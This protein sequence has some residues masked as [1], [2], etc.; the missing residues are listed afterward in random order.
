MGVN[1]PFIT[2]LGPS[3]LL[4]VRLQD[5]VNLGDSGLGLGRGALLTQLV[6]S[7]HAVGDH[8][9]AATFQVDLALIGIAFVEHI[10]N[11]AVIEFVL[12]LRQPFA[13]AV[14]DADHGQQHGIGD[15]GRELFPHAEFGLQFLG[16]CCTCRRIVRQ[17]V[18]PAFN[19]KLLQGFGEVADWRICQSQAIDVGLTQTTRSAGKQQAITAFDPGWSC[20]R[21]TRK[22]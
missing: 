5:A 21:Q 16:C 1:N 22:Q 7:M 6:A 18:K 19:Q 8:A 11:D 10:V 20:G 9:E 14:D 3:T 15:Q 2:L 4:L 17:D 12:V 13:L